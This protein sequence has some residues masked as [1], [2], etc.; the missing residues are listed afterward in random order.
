MNASRSTSDQDSITTVP[1][2]VLRPRLEQNVWRVN[3]VLVEDDP[4]DAEL[5]TRALKQNSDV[6]SIRAHNSPQE[7]L[8][9]LRDEHFVP[10][11]ILAD[12]HMPRMDGFQFLD[13]VR[14]IEH[15]KDVPV[16]FLTTSSLAR[17]VEEARQSTACKYIVKPTN[18]SELQ[19][20]LNELVKQMIAGTR[21]K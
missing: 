13:L 2:T 15:M 3:V 9:E 8:D 12:V 6:A 1:R 18:Y 5:I 16:V 20:R 14:R 10:T 21:R 11:V 4:A 7:A 19:E 17:D